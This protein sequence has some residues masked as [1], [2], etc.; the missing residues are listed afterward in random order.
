MKKVNFPLGSRC[1]KQIPDIDLSE[2]FDDIEDDRRVNRLKRQFIPLENFCSN[3]F[4]PEDMY[5]QEEEDGNRKLRETL[6]E[7]KILAR[8]KNIKRIREERKKR[9]FEELCKADHPLRKL[10][11]EDNI[12]S[13]E[14]EKVP[15]TLG[16]KPRGRLILQH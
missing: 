12:F 4:N 2:I 13:I 7:E 9:E 15:K 3:E 16:I 10:P 14:F 8:A 6:Y 1:C 11:V 5:I